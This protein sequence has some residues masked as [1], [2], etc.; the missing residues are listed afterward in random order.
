MAALAG[1]CHR[2]DP[3]YVFD[4]FALGT[5]YHIVVSLPD[6][7][8]LSAAVENLFET[9]S[10]SMSVYDPNSLLNRL[11]RN[12]TDS[13]D[14]YIADCIAIAR[15]VSEFSGGI[16]DITIKPVTQ[17]WGFT[18]QDPDRK[19]NLDSLLR[20][21][22]YEKISVADGK[23]I[24]DDPLIQIELNSVAKGYIVDLLGELMAERGSA[25]YLVEVGGEV[26]CR[27]AN[28]KGEKWKI[29]IDKPEYGNMIPG[30]NEQAVL[31]FTGKGLATSGNYR[32]FYIDEEG[33][34]VVH[35]VNAVTGESSPSNLLSVTVIARTCALA[36]A[37][38]T[39]FMAVGLERS[40]AFLESQ[41]DVLGYLV[42]DDGN[43][44]Y[45]VW[46]SPAME[47]AIVR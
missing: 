23:L 2:P 28:R 26:V 42:F 30:M 9:T 16:Y 43:G 25:D 44:G 22:G 39:M 10:A 41:D 35:T 4:G 32:K 21:V 11:N 45:G 7:A 47:E 46:Y 37:F 14:S 20:Y 40:V 24:K 8:G 18:G 1:S 12:E 31:S 19:P 15:E 33:N 17:A 13:I 34:R 27:G 36:D 3:Y 6:T 38:G 5:T 29:M